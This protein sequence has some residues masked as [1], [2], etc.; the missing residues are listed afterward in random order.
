MAALPASAAT[1]TF[2][3]ISVDD[4]GQ[5]SAVPDASLVDFNALGLGTQN[6]SA[7]IAT[8]T[9]VDIFQCACTGNGDVRD[10]TTNAASASGG[11]FY[12]IDF[13]QPISYFGVYWG[14]PDQGN[15]LRLF[16]GAALVR[17]VTGLEVGNVVGFGLPGGGYVNVFAD[18]GEHF[19]RA[20]FVGGQF[21]LESDNHAFA[22]PEPTAVLL[23]TTG[24]VGLIGRPR[25]K[26]QRQRSAK[27]KGTR[28]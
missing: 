12:T 28:A 16:D 22:V 7:G 27:E 11:G 2:G 18:A 26:H 5:F 10:D 1:I 3:G 6:F 23:L 15:E 21:P 19:T 13:S 24:V 25:S 17:T 14:S 8:Y 20:V 9:D 4:Q